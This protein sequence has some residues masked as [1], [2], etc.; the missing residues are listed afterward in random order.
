MSMNQ[1][2]SERLVIGYKVQNTVEII[3]LLIVIN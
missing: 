3:I 2:V 1:Q